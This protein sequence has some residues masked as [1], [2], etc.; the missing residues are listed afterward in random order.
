MKSEIRVELVLAIIL[1]F[2][3]RSVLQKRKF[4]KKDYQNLSL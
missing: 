4:S 1:K 3:K 2:W